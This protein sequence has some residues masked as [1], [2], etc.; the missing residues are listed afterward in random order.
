MWIQYGIW[1]SYCTILYSG[2]QK[3]NL[4]LEINWKVYDFDYDSEKKKYYSD[5]S[6]YSAQVLLSLKL[7]K[8]ISKRNSEIH[9]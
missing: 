5:Y 8:D 2:V 9:I 1:K 6:A 3:I 7:K 4:I